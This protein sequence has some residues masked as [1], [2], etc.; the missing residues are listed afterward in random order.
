M[1]ACLLVISVFVLS[2]QYSDSTRRYCCPGPMQFQ[3]STA[4]LIPYTINA[5]YGRSA[6]LTKL[7]YHLFVVLL[8]HPFLQLFVQQL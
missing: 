8:P 2:R 7:S 1:S 6:L 4:A 3:G 5:E